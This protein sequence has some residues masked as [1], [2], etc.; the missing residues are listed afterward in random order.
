MSLGGELKVGA[1]AG[2]VS[3]GPFELDTGKEVTEEVIDAGLKPSPKSSPLRQRK[4]P[5]CQLQTH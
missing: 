3:V 4:T 1:G 5:Q 2:E